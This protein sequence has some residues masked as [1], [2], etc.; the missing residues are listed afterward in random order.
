MR[1]V[2]KLFIAALAVVL[3]SADDALA[4]GPAVHIGLADTIWGQLGLLPAAVAAVLA[5]HRTAFFYGSISADVVFAKRLSRIK[6]FCH[7]WST[8]FRVL[9]AAKDDRAKSFAYGY[10]SHLAADTVA[11]GKYVPRQIVLSNSP[12]NAGHL[13]WELRADA[14]CDPEIHALVKD[15][16]HADHR[17][18]HALLS[19]HLKGTFLPYDLNRV[20]FHRMNVLTVKPVFRKSMDV[21]SRRSKYYLAPELLGGYHSECVD[22]IVSILAEGHRS[23]LTRE[24]PNGT[25]ALM[26]LSVHR[27]ETKRLERRGHSVSHR[28]AEA[29]RGLS[30]TGA[31]SPA[32]IGEPRSTDAQPAA[33][34]GAVSLHM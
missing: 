3:I 32:P 13:Y 28:R 18:H 14:I 2:L 25:S 11:H 27:R 29:S 15:V 26:Q 24:D 17:D 4:W 16:L 6:Q 8:A 34:A 1:S 19:D 10:L 9:D 30:P 20:L 31:P 23:A 12:V 7:H 21:W 22:R 33:I 5:R